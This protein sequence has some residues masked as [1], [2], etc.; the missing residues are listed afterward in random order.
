MIMSFGINGLNLLATSTYLQ[1][2]IVGVIIIVSVWIGILR[3]K[4]V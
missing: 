4:G 2:V 1:D 3:R